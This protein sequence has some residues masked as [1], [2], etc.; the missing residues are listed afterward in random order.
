MKH[1]NRLLGVKCMDINLGENTASR[2]WASILIRQ[3]CTENHVGRLSYWQK[4]RTFRSKGTLDPLSF[5]KDSGHVEELCH[6][7]WLEHNLI[8]GQE[9]PQRSFVFS[10]TC[11][12]KCE[13]E[14]TL[15]ADHK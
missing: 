12:D 1:T 7:V 6:E 4:L 8:K 9:Q 10:T 3:K 15:P 5:W 11:Q 14:T 13:E 2:K